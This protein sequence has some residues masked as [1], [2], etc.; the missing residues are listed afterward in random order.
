LALDLATSVLF[1][2]VSDSFADPFESALVLLLSES[3][4]L[5]LSPLFDDFEDLLDLSESESESLLLLSSP[6]SPNAFAAALPALD[7]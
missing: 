2:F 7:I 3:D 4:F 6:P 1:F 5:L